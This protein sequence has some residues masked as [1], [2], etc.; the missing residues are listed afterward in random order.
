MASKRDESARELQPPAPPIP[1]YERRRPVKGDLVMIGGHEEKKGDR[2]ILREVARR[3]DGGALV[4]ATVGSNEAD[5]L[6][7]EYERVFRALGV[8][9]VRHLRAET[10]EQVLDDPPLGKL[11]DARV[12]FFTGGAQMKI[13]TTLGGTVLCDRIRKIYEEGGTIAGT[14][15]GA[16]VMS[17]T[18]LVSGNG[19]ETHTI[20]GQ[21]SMAPGLGL[22]QDVIVDQH[23]SERGRIGRLLGAVAQNPRLLGV[24]LDE[25]T[26][27]V[28]ERER[29]MLVLGTGAAYVLDAASVSYTNLSDEQEQRAMS[30]F[31]VRL[32]VLSQGD[33]YDLAS[34]TPTAE[35]AAQVEKELLGR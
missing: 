11:D 16:S 26:A 10:R 12:I 19:D 6:A 7:D 3:V 2:I 25:N 14:S 17:E 5:A 15:A 28:V 22:L 20:G 32:H 21:L 31:D 8:R 33:R 1:A 23:F 9:H 18:M 27:I 30:V 35:F 24:G 34:R 13:T 29:H 4:I